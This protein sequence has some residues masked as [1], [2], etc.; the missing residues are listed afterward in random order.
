MLSASLEEAVIDYDVIGQ[1]VAPTGEL[2][3][4][5]LVACVRWHLDRDWTL[6]REG[7]PAQQPGWAYE[8]LLS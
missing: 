3:T 5:I 4:K 6:C 1:A 8:W 7:S 2:A